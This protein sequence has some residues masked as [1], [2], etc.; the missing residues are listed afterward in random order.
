MNI[1][2]EAVEAA[3]K[4]LRIDLTEIKNR[5]INVDANAYLNIMPDHWDARGAYMD[6]RDLLRLVQELQSRSKG[7][8]E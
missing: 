8:G 5:Q 2:D 7:A 3:A 1:P 6:R 4:R